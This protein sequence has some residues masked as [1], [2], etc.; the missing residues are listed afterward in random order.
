MVKCKNCKKET[1]ALSKGMCMTCYKRF[2]WKPKKKICKR[3]N[4]E[5]VMHAKGYCPGCYNFVFHLAKNREVTYIKYHNITPELYK[6]LTEKCVIC[7]F[8]S[9]VDLHHL[10][11]DKTNNS[12]ANLIG[13][14]PNH[15]KMLHHTNFKN[16]VI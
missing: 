7:G 15:H 2:G 12:E 10:D 16:E 4:R 5:M 11:E 14:C 1:S 8:S 9:V 13:L 6:K 3:C